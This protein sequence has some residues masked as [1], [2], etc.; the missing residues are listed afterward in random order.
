MERDIVRGKALLGL[1]ALGLAV[2]CGAADDAEAEPSNAHAAEVGVRS[3]TVA[4]PEGGAAG[5]V[6]LSIRYGFTETVTI[7][8]PQPLAPDAV[9]P[10]LVQPSEI[11]LG[12]DLPG[13][14]YYL[15]YQVTPLSR[16]RRGAAFEG[17]AP[18]YVAGDDYVSR[19]SFSTR[20]S[21]ATPIDLPE[22][23]HGI[24]PDGF[25]IRVS[26]GHATGEIAAP[27]PPANVTLA[28][29]CRL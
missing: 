9:L 13:R 14:G 17:D 19:P 7:V 29:A 6:S 2:G 12:E 3:R 1:A 20:I 10:I 27:P 23:V 24:D 15:D 21:D 18:G 25:V 5:G 22:R 4:C 26:Y 28:F 11:E 16:D 8:S